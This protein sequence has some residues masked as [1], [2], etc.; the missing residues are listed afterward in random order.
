MSSG[1][2][3]A[4]VIR[5]TKTAQIYVGITSQPL[6]KRWAQHRQSARKGRSKLAAAMREFGFETFSIE[7]V[8]CCATYHDLRHCEMMLI[9]QY[10]SLADGLNATA[11]GAGTPGCLW[12][13]EA[14]EK[15]RKHKLR[16]WSDPAYREG[17]SEAQRAAWACKSPDLVQAHAERAAITLSKR[18]AEKL[19]AA[20]KRSMFGP[21]KG[22]GFNSRMKT[23]C[24]QGHAYD[25]ENTRW[26]PSGKRLCRTCRN[27]QQNALRARN[28]AAGK[29]RNK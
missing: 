24:A 10:N 5:S 19:L 15:M 3:T 4:Y 26:T 29:R 18:H 23:H 14:R 13:E 12:P 20:P 27:N 16:H 9:A 22:K 2:F 1:I 25:R 11:G 17:I 7:P 21:F 8:L 28:A 6:R